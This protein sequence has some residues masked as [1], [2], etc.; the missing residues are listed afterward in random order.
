MGGTAMLDV[1][2]KLVDLLETVLAKE[3]PGEQEPDVND[4]L[5]AIGDSLEALVMDI[6]DRT[7]S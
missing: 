6:R 4:R 2:A 1:L 7:K 3:I 5:S